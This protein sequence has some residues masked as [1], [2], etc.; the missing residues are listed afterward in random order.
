MAARRSIRDETAKARQQL[1]S[2]AAA[3][4]VEIA[5]QQV[6]TNITGSDRERLTHD[7][8]NQLDNGVGHG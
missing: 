1:R 6:T 5:T 3:L 4:A 2:D 7:F 8:L